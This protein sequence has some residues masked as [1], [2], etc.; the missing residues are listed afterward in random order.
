M[1]GYG[2]GIMGAAITV[3][4]K[5]SYN[6][7]VAQINNGTYESHYQKRKVSKIPLTSDTEQTE[8][9]GTFARLLA[10]VF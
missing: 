7:T 10:K 4:T 6:E 8:E 5:E 3:H 9:E 2:H 1:C